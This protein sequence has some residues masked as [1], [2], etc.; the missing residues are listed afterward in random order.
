MLKLIYKF[1]LISIMSFSLITMNTIS[2]A[3]DVQS[4]PNN[5]NSAISQMSQPN[6]DG[7]YRDSNGVLK[8]NENHKFEGTKDDD[9]LNIITM[10]VIG[11]IGMKLILYEKRT[12]DMLV[13]V[14]ASGAYILAEIANI[15]NLKSQLKGMSVDVTKS[16]DGKVDQAQIETLEKLKLSYQKAKQS[17]KTRKMLQVTAAAAYT[18]AVGVA[19]YERLHVDGLLRSCNA[20]IDTVAAKLTVHAKRKISEAEILSMDGDQPGAGRA[21]MA[22]SHAEACKARLVE[23]KANLA[24]DH[25]IWNKSGPSIVKSPEEKISDNKNLARAS[26]PC[27]DAEAEAVRGS[28][29]INACQSYIV[30]KGQFS[31]YGF[32]D[33]LFTSQNLPSN[34]EKMLISNINNSVMSN[35]NINKS[36]S[37]GFQLILDYLLPRAEAGV[38]SLF[39]LGAGALAAYM[40]TEL[41]FAHKIDDQIFTPGGRIILWSALTAIT[42]YAIYATQKEIDKIDGHINEIDQ[43][44]KDLYTLKS[45][46]KSNNVNEQQIKLASLKPIQEVDLQLNPNASFKSDCLGGS[47]GSNCA[48]L[49]DQMKSMPGYSELPDSFKTIASQATRIGDGLSGTNKISAA[50]LTSAGSFSGQIKA[51]GKLNDTLKTKLNESLAKDGM[52]KVDFDKETKNL[53]NN[54]VTTTGKALQSSGMSSGTFLAS[55]GVGPVNSPPVAKISKP[56]FIS[57]ATV[58]APVKEKKPEFTLDL[59]ENTNSADVVGGSNR[60]APKEKFDIGAND[61]NTNSGDSIFQMISNRYFK[62]GYPKLLDEI[63]VKK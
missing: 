14:A 30:A 32:I 59:K 5:T 50:T 40:T 31:A 19:T 37:H 7:V 27:K 56:V 11:I 41:A 18:T 39:A 60:S 44:L 47:L 46:V 61:I 43:I 8:K 34:S 17:A 4:S 3:Q 24:V 16:S 57:P 23:F 52:P 55:M 26:E 20:A 42:G 22:S 15:A 51:I 6:S 58:I 62:S 28:A 53:T 29:V 2:L 49:S 36:S 54:L 63:P 38:I 9:P 25:G 35:F 45:G 12:P 21:I 33:K 13:V 48:S 10:L 1:F